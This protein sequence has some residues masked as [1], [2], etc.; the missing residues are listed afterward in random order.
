M[1]LIT[2]VGEG[3]GAALVR[4]FSR[5][6]YR[7]AML[8]RNRERLKKLEAELPAAKGYVCDVSDLD[9]LLRTV[10]A[11]RADLG[12]PTVLVHNAVRANFETFLDG[13]P[14]DL[15][16]NFRVNTAL[17]LKAFLPKKAPFCL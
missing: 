3:T 12:A 9:A 8:A 1:A 14:E 16:R 10:E 17:P 6:G 2:G 7:L 15:E 4:R 13:D 5:G 11:V